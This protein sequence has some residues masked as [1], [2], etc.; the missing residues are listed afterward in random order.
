[1]T[2]YW[3]DISLQVRDATTVEE[4]VQIENQVSQIVRL[5]IG[6]REFPNDLREEIMTIMSVWQIDPEL[7]LQSEQ[8]RSYYGAVK[9]SRMCQELHMVF[10][11]VAERKIKTRF[12]VITDDPQESLR[13]RDRHDDP[14]N[15]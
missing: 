13:D 8:G 1:M 5:L 14:S 12:G 15:S 7:G 2:A 3:D 9:I 11:R 6:D 4:V 10:H